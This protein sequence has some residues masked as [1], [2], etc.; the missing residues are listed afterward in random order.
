[1]NIGGTLVH[2][3]A[4]ADGKG[5]CIDLLGFT[6]AG[7]ITVTSGGILP[8]SVIGPILP[9]NTW[10][11]VAATYSA[12]RGFRLYVNGTFVGT[13]GS[14]SYLPWSNNNYLTLGNSLDAWLNSF[15]FSLCLTYSIVGRPYRGSIDEFRIYARELNST[16]LWMLIN[17]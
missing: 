14:I 5:L 10:T 15:G 2:L 9:V 6:A 16:E 11:H 8:F 12:I 17:S 7:E 13:T 3:S 1:M 4:N